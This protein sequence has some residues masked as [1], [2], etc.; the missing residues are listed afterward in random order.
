MSGPTVATGTILDRILER[1]AADLAV[2]KR[3]VS[4][5]AIEQRAAE[6]MPPVSLRNALIGPGTAV[7]AEIKRASPSRGLFP[8][9]VDPADVAADYLVGGAAAIS[10]LTDE[11]FFRGSL[12][13]LEATATAAHERDRPAP[14]L[15]KDFVLDAYQIVEGRAFGADAILLIVAALTDGALR[16]LML[17]TR[18]QGMEALVEVHDEGELERAVAAGA[19]VIGINNRDLRTFE[20]D[21]GVAER[22]APLVPAGTVIVGESGV[23]SRADVERLARAGV[24][25]VLVGESLIVSPDRASAVRTLRGEGGP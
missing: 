22:L 19:G 5:A 1:T 14:V 25:A 4:P 2:R 8:V 21:L 13:D 15:R 9:V 10:C 24:H 16:E 7:I 12:A 11:P 6:R 20:V 17:A 23:A 18:E 3:L